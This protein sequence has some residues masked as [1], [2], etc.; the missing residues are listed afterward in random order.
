MCY[1]FV[2]AAASCCHVCCHCFVYYTTAPYQILYYLVH[3]FILPLL[4]ILP[5]LRFYQV[6]SGSTALLPLV[7]TVLGTLHT[8]LQKNLVDSTASA[9]ASYITA[10]APCCHCSIPTFC[11]YF[12]LPLPRLLVVQ[13]V[14]LNATAPLPVTP[15]AAMPPHPSL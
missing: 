12:K 3:R 5:R 4:R 10:T 14:S 2:N 13:R 7:C 8:T 6:L 9:A 1:G 15:W 11:Y